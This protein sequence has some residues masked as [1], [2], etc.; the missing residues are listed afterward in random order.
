MECRKKKKAKDMGTRD[1]WIERGHGEQEN[2]KRIQLHHTEELFLY[3]HSHFIT[4]SMAYGTRR[5]N[6]A[7]TRALQ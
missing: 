1:G 7:F 3:V 4:N 5:F 6:A 2:M